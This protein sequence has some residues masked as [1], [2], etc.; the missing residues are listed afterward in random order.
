MRRVTE[1]QRLGGIVLLRTTAALLATLIAVQPT[2]AADI[3]RTL[4]CTVGKKPMSLVYRGDEYSGTLDAKTPWG[5][6]QFADVTYSQ[7]EDDFN[8][9]AAQDQPAVVMPDLAKLQACLKKL[10]NT[11]DEL[12][13]LN[14]LQIDTEYC[15]P[16]TPDGDAVPALVEINVSQDHDY[17]LDVDVYRTYSV[18]SPVADG[19]IVIVLPEEQSPQCTAVEE[20]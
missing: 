5:E 20:D 15:A 2:L 9:Q 3:T 11:A 1:R 7:Y 10:S 14:L 8:V 19:H 18:G 16:R 12:M 17:G 6:M 13:D 4:N